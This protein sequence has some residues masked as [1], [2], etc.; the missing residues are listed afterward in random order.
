MR[1]V[2]VTQIFTVIHRNMNKNQ[3]LPQE[4]RKGC[5]FSPTKPQKV[6][7]KDN[8]HLSLSMPRAN[9]SLYAD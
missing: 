2:R 9:N 6:S 7:F 3:R 5:G 8:R 4:T 1:A